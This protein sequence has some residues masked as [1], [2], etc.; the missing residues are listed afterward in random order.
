VRERARLSD[1]AWFEKYRPTVG[2]SIVAVADPERVRAYNA[3]VAEL[4]QAAG[5]VLGQPARQTCFAAYC[6]DEDGFRRRV[7]EAAER[8]TTNPVGLLIRMVQAG[9]HR[10][11][12]TA[13]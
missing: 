4:E 1:E 11:G 10:I 3:L 12:E 5:K 7:D 13:S 2:A 8:G 9:E 6:E